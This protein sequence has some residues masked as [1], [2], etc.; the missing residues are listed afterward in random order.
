MDRL[1]LDHL[2]Q[3][4]VVLYDDM[5]AIEVGMEFL[6]TKAYQQT[7]SLSVCMA[8]LNVSKH[9]TGESYEATLWIRVAL[10]QYSLEYICTMTGIDLS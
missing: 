4:V 10:N 7:I 6:Q 3:L 5:P 8:S 2:Q 1:M 9:F